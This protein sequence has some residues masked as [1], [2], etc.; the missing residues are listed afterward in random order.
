ML[1]LFLRSIELI[2]GGWYNDDVCV[3]HGFVPLLVSDWMYVFRYLSVSCTQKTKANMP[4]VVTINH[5]QTIQATQ[6]DLTDLK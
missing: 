5:A 3:L 1:N 4:E 2:H 6:N